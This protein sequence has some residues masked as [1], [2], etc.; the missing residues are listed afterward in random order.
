MSQTLITALNNEVRQVGEPLEGNCFYRHRSNFQLR[1]NTERLR[2]DLVRFARYGRNILEIGTNA[3][4]SLALINE[5]ISKEEYN[6]GMIV[7][8]DKCFHKYTKPCMDIFREHSN[9][10]FMFLE[11]TS[12]KVLPELN[13]NG[14][15]IRFDKIHIDGGHTERAL[16]NDIEMCY[17]LSTK[18]TIVCID[19]TNFTKIKKICDEYISNGLLTEVSDTYFEDYKWDTKFHRLYKYVY[20]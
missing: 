9:K 16:R 7:G 14:T 2:A 4:H 1:P 20:D 19:D 5:G 11:G 15:Y 18:E 3:G 12:E 10:D 8:I 6:K 13:S 17:N